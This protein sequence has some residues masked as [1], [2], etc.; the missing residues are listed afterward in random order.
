MSEHLYMYQG[1]WFEPIE[2]VMYLQEHFKPRPVDVLLA[3]ALKCGTTWLKGLI[4]SIINR[5][6]YDA[7]AKDHP[8]LTADVHECMPF[9]EVHLFGDLP[10]GDAEILSSPIF[11]RTNVPLPRIASSRSV[12]SDLGHQTQTESP[13]KEKTLSR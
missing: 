8:L 5:T 11:V 10:I 9:L 1:Y 6:C 13:R 2:G 7:S 4:F 12:Y 3:T